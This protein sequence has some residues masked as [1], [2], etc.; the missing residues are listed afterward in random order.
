M[1]FLGICSTWC[2]VDLETIFALFENR[3]SKIASF[4]F[5]RVPRMVYV[6][7]FVI[8]FSH[9]EDS[10]VSYEMTVLHKEYSVVRIAFKANSL[11]LFG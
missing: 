8:N 10:E 1:V 3:Y 6:R 9:I 2:L 5:F 7:C 4:A 11:L